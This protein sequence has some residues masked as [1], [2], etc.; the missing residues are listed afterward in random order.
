MGYE[1]QKKGGGPLINEFL[2]VCFFDVF[3]QS[4]RFIFLPSKRYSVLRCGVSVDSRAGGGE[5][6]TNVFL[7]VCFDVFQQSSL[8]LK[9]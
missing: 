4:S 1:L 5:L 3:R 8:L 6:L 2:R 9:R 7:R